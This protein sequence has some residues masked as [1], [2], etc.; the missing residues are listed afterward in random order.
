MV[1]RSGI[2]S[3]IVVVGSMS[4]CSGSEEAVSVG[5][6][7]EAVTPSALVPTAAVVSTAASEL[8]YSAD[9]AISPTGAA[10]VASVDGEW[11]LEDASG[12]RC[13]AAAAEGSASHGV[14][15]RPDEAA[16]AVTWGAQDAISIIDFDEG[17]TVETDLDSHRLLAW[18]PDGASLLGLDI[19][20][21]A[22]LSRLDPA[23]LEASRFAAFDLAGVPQLDWPIDDVAWGS[24][25]GAPE[26]FTIEPDGRPELIPG[27]IGEQLLASVTADGRYALGIDDDVVRGTAGTDT[28]ALTLF[29]RDGSRSVGVDLPDEIAGM[30]ISDAQ[31]SADGRG[32]LVLH[33]TDEGRALSSARV[34]LDTLAATSWTTIATWAEGADDAPIAYASNGVLRWTGGDVAWLI[35]AAGQLLVVELR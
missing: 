27:G 4:A 26:V 2:V 10:R 11:C 8:S 22:Q 21:P 30:G 15:W 32:L 9:S 13:V 18:S 23:T 24:M 3:A 29:E 34:D 5:D 14:A 35:G 31:L 33:D 25:P 20:E 17:T 6:T 19:D 28:S 12:V 1:F 7:V 16:I